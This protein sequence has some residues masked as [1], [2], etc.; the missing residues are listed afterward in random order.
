MSSVIID[1]LEFGVTFIDSILPLLTD[2]NGQVVSLRRQLS[3]LNDLFSFSEH[4]QGCCIV[5]LPEEL[6]EET[7]RNA[8]RVVDYS[9][10]QPEI[11]PVARLSVAGVLHP[12]RS[13]ACSF[14]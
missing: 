9:F 3:L 10:P 6:T 12:D 4:S 13:K 14:M 2:P 11:Q 7:T 1:P 5:Y 8:V